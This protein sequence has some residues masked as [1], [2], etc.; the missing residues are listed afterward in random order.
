MNKE[1]REIKAL[2]TLL[3][4]ENGEI[5]HHV[6]DRLVGYGNEV[7]PNLEAAW[8]E[9]FNPL[10]QQRIEDIVHRIQYVGVE[11]ALQDWVKGSQNLLE[12]WL[13]LTRYQYPDLDASKIIA[14]IDR[15]KKD[16]W[17]ELNEEQTALEKIKILNHILFA[18]HGFAGNSTNYHAPGNN[19]LNNVMESKKGNAVSLA[20]LYVILAQKLGLPVYGVNLP[21]HFVLCYKDESPVTMLFNLSDEERILF[22]INPLNRGSVFSRREIDVFLKRLNLSYH[23][24]YYAP[25]SNIT[26]LRQLVQN[27]IRAYREDGRTEKCTELEN[28]LEI[29]KVDNE[30]L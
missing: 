17:I 21:E 24:P 13:A 22:Y 18:I 7:V 9:S 26:I 23:K 12:G 19:F 29:L 6:R 1:E 3:D 15:I 20:G 16:A 11:S 8:E 4:D 27:L 30:N 10:I 2:I 28:L 14:Q 5:F 25:A